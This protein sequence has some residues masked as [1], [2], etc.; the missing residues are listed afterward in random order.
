[1]SALKNTQQIAV[2]YEL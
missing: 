1:M 2:C